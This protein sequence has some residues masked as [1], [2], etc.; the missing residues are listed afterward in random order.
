MLYSPAGKIGMVISAEALIT[1]PLY[2]LSPTVT[3]TLPVASFGTITEIV[4]FLSSF[5]SG[6]VIFKS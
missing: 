3:V 4:V 1:V 5:I 2:F 6:I